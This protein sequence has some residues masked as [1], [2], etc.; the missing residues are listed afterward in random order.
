M[1]DKFE[2][3]EKKVDNIDILWINVYTSLVVKNSSLAKTEADKA[4]KLY[5]E[6]FSHGNS[7]NIV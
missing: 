6:R 2:T 4:V 1:S 5:K 7:Q 3:P